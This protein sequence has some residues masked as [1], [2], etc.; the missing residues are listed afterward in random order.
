MGGYTDNGWASTNLGWDFLKMCG[1]VFK[2]GWHL[3]RNYSNLRQHC[4]TTFWEG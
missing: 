2:A 4:I 3:Q 1:K